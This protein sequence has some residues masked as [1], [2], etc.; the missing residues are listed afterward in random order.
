MPPPLQLRESHRRPC[1]P[2]SAAPTACR[3]DRACGDPRHRSAPLGRRPWRR[4]GSPRE[5]AHSTGPQHRR[6]WRRRGRPPRVVLGCWPHRAG[7]HLRATMLSH[8]H[9]EPTVRSFT[10]TPTTASYILDNG[11]C[12]SD[13]LDGGRP[14]SLTLHSLRPLRVPHRCDSDA[15]SLAF[16]DMPSRGDVSAFLM[17]SDEFQHITLHRRFF[18]MQAVHPSINLS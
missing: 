17:R 10:P 12:I 16:D 15:T 6:P 13:V 11:T 4:R 9:A 1:S 3:P 7:T 2:R 8:H 18:S 14:Y 5:G